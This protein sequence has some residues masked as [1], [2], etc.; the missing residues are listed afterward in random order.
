MS[1]GKEADAVVSAVFFPVLVLR[2]RR[3]DRTLCKGFAGVLFTFKLDMGGAEG[4]N[5]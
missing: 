5:S 2:L 1:R 4:V 3:Y